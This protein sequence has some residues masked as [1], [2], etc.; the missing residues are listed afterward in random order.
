MKRL[1]FAAMLSV[2][3]AGL[4]ILTACGG[5][6]NNQLSITLTTGNGLM[7]VDES[8]GGANSMLE[9]IAAVGGDTAAKGVTWTFEKQSGCSGSGTGSGSCGTLTQVAGQPNTLSIS[10]I[11]RRRLRRRNL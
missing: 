9:I 2:A 3:C 10:S 7:Q 8:T 1:R 4:M 6:G 11:R 5:G